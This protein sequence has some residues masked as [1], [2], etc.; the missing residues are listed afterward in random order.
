MKTENY[1]SPP[2]FIIRLEQFFYYLLI[3]LLPTQLGKHYWPDFSYVHG[4]RIDYLPPTIYMTDLLVGLLFIMW[5]IRR[6]RGKPQ[7][8]SKIPPK[9]RLAKG[10]KSQILKIQ[11]KNKK[12]Y[13]VGLFAFCF[14]LFNILL[15]GR[16][17][18]SLYSL[19]KVLEMAFL[20]YYTAKF[21]DV[22]KYFSRIVLLLSIGV[23]FESLLA[24]VHYFKQGSVGGILY[25]L[26]ERTFSASTPGI[27]NVSLNGE[28]MLRPYGTFP[29]PNV[30]AGY[31]VVVMTVVLYWLVLLKPSK[32]LSIKYQVLSI[33]K[34]LTSHFLI[35]TSALLALALGTT[36]LFLSMGRAAI[37]LW[38]LIVAY[39]L[40][41]KV[42]KKIY[43]I[44]ALVLA[45]FFLVTPLGGRFTDVNIADESFTRRYELTDAALVML[46]SSPIFG[47]GLGNFIPVLAD[48][49]KPLTVGTYLQ[50]AHNIF[51][52]AAAET[53]LIGLGFFLVFIYKTFRRIMNYTSAPLSTSELRIKEPLLIVF[54]AI[55]ILGLFDHYWLTL[56][57]GQL[58]FAFVTGLCWAEIGEKRL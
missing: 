47:V 5:L 6:V 10:G 34:K 9:A 32:V 45:I 41:K 11:I 16:I 51:F 35:L 48:M 27:A 26:G 21:V 17:E 42:R 36:A 20:A 56:Q 1:N 54:S 25:F 23:I 58:L 29:H 40:I 37:L 24:I 50:P 31:L 12:Y 49:Q 30:L 39:V 55:L 28:L 7:K 8:K 3:L 38:L 46:K 52:L 22:K 33:K 53:G 15:S 18:G 4:I 13:L 19:L 43:L 57:Q 2:S 14:L 44:A